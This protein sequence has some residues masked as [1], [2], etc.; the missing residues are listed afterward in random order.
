MW[1]GNEGPPLVVLDEVDGM[2]AGPAVRREGM[3]AGPAVRR[4]GME[5]GP[6]VRREAPLIKLL[7]RG[8]INLTATLHR[9]TRHLTSFFYS[10]KYPTLHPPPPPPTATQSHFHINIAHAGRSV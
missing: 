3:E 5:A 1:A 8:L 2:E 7:R 6:A 9:S 4:E 10:H